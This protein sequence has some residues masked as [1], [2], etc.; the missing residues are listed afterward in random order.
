MITKAD[1]LREVENLL[2]EKLEFDDSSLNEGALSIKKMELKVR[3]IRSKLEMIELR[4][5]LTRSIEQE[6]LETI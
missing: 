2:S 3:D 5:R 4:E 6:V 1:L